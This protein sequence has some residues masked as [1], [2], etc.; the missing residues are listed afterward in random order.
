MG[1][2]GDFDLLC[3]PRG[4]PGLRRPEVSSSGLAAFST[5]GQYSMQSLHLQCIENRWW[6]TL[7]AMSSAAAAVWVCEPVVVG[8]TG[9][10]ADAAA[11]SRYKH[12]SASVNRDCCCGRF[13]LLVT[14]CELSFLFR[15]GK[16][17]LR[18]ISAVFG[19]LRAL[20]RQARKREQSAPA[21]NSE[22]VISV[23]QCGREATE[24]E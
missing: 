17:R 13:R 20:G 9:I 10:G 22:N 4:R 15:M 8:G 16:K 7:A 1:G 14:A 23:L 5:G 3:A 6:L 11:P 18:R 21:A 12:R 24:S 2:G 19:M